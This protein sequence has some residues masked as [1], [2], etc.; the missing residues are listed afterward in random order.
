MNRKV[1]YPA[2]RIAIIFLIIGMLWIIFTDRLV[3]LISQDLLTATLYQNLKG[4]FFVLIVAFI[5]YRLILSELKQQH[6]LSAELRQS[7]KKYASLFNNLNDGAV[8]HELNGTQGTGQIIELNNTICRLSGY[9]RDDLSRM[10]IF[11]LFIKEDHEKLN[12]L[13]EKIRKEFHMIMELTLIAEDGLLIDTELSSHLFTYS[14]REVILTVVRDIR[15]RKKADRQLKEAF[16]FNASVLNSISEGL[17]VLDPHLECQIW[18]RAMEEL[19]GISASQASHK[20]ILQ[21]LPFLDKTD[22]K[23]AMQE[24]LDGV[25]SLTKGVSCEINGKKVWIRSIWSPNISAEAEVIGVIGILQDITRDK[26]AALEL[27]AQKEKA[28]ESDRLKSA[29]LA[30]ISHEI[31]TPL[32]GILGFSELLAEEDASRQKIV[33]ADIIRKNVR[34]LLQ[35]ISDIIDISHIESSQL[36]ITE[37]EVSLAVLLDEIK[38]ILDSILP[39]NGSDIT[40]K[41]KHELPQEIDLIRTDGE[42]IKQVMHHLLSNAVKFTSHG[43]I[44]TGCSV[45][46]HSMLRLYVKDSGIGIPEEEQSMIFEPFRQGKRHYTGELGGTGLGLAIARGIVKAMGGEMELESSPGHGSCFSF[47]IPIRTTQTGS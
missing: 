24:A 17:L 22:L 41:H 33:Y 4:G 14:D 25:C 21:I 45:E 13:L 36:A 28:E 9:K 37:N 35:I 7:H 44:E 1:F 39:E 6:L 29:F 31:R 18:N 46:D 8:L 40:L 42:R 20:H 38:A 26:L 2:R 15:E 23:Q 19:T 5:L 43:S 12:A 11:Q 3:Q 27:Q 10:N 32:N 30:N 16:R 47:W 34:Q